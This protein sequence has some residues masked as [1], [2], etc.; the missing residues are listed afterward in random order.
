[1]EDAGVPSPFSQTPSARVHT[2]PEEREEAHLH[3]LVALLV[4]IVLS[5]LPSLQHFCDAC[6]W[7]GTS[8]CF[9]LDASAL[10]QCLETCQTKALHLFLS[11]LCPQVS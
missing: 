7:A 1:M 4:H 2:A 9:T 11:L 8:L 3:Q 6:A 5:S 10:L